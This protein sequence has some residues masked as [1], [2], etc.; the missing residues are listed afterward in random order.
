MNNKIAIL[1]PAYEPDRHL[2][3]LVAEIEEEQNLK[4]LPLIVVDDGTK[5]QTIFDQLHA[6]YSQLVILHHAQNKGKGGALKTGF[7]Y[8]IENMPEIA[9][10]ATLDADGQHKVADLKKCLAAFRPDELVLGVRNFN[11][12]VPWRSRFGN[13]LTSFLVKK[14]T[15][16]DFQDTQTGLRVIPVSYAQKCLAFPA[17]DYAFEFDMLLAAKENGLAVKQVPISTV[18]EKGNPTSHFDVTPKIGTILGVISQLV[19]PDVEYDSIDG[20]RLKG[21]T[22]KPLNDQPSFDEIK[23][24]VLAF[25]ADFPWVGY[26]IKGWDIPVLINN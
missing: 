1:I 3:S 18:Y 11:Q 22:Y 23:N 20:L 24:D 6:K 21:M 19:N 12:D 8:I 13:Q 17:N 26:G 14:T 9:G 4:D 5:E 16:S 7:N 2:L 15:G 10:I 25:V